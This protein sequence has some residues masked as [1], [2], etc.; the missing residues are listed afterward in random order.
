MLT[1]VSGPARRG[2]HARSPRRPG[3]PVEPGHHERV[4]LW[5]LL[6][7]DGGAAS[8]LGY[9]FGVG[10]PSGG[11]Y[12]IALGRINLL[13]ARRLIEVGQDGDQRPAGMPNQRAKTLHT[14]AGPI[15]D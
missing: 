5:L 2:E 1:R 13:A 7:T 9:R 6:G 3:E 8:S 10:G 11:Q 14:Q 12:A 15:P 4:A